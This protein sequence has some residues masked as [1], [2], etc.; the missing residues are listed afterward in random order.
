V[1][2]CSEDA[3]SGTILQAQGGQFSVA[4]IVES[5]WVNLGDKCTVEGVAESW[6]KISDLSAAK[7][8]GR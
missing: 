5:P 8:R 7:P 6:S 4:T 2:L 1:Y 3:P